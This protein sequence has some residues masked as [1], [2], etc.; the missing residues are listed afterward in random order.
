MLVGL[1]VLGVL[2]AIGTA[3]ADNT[4]ST[5]GLQPVD[6]IQP[7]N[8]PIGAD[9]SL[10]GLKIA[11]ENLDETF[12]FNQSERLDKEIDHSDLRLAEL[13]SALAANRTDAADRAL[14][15][16]WQKM[17]QTGQTLELFNG[18]GFMPGYNETYN[19]TWPMSGFNGT[20]PMP[21]P[22]DDALVHAQE[23]I[24]SHQ[25][26]LENLLLSHPDNPGLARAY[27]NSHAL[28][29][30][31]E[32]KTLTQFELSRDADNRAMFRAEYL[33]SSSQNQVWNQT[34]PAYT[35]RGQGFNVNG[36]IPEE[37]NHTG[38]ITGHTWNGTGQFS[39][40]TN[41]SW[42]TQQHQEVTQEIPGHGQNPA[43]DRQ[44]RNGDDRGTNQR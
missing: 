30:M 12:T 3:A 13:E 14:D 33:N 25:I 38:E 9:S 24:L 22:F 1:M 16:Y 44:N 6:T 32:Q 4:T 37:W 31:F 42:Q 19:R 11:F 26:A 17:N 5:Q 21:S 35:Q 40:E 34:I 28:E 27:N 7:Y 15:Q 36:T 29:Q 2:C 20:G 18:T 39:Q 10:Y 41:Q 23:M 43:N 8:G